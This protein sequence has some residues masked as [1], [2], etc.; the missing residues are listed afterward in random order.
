[1]SHTTRAARLFYG[2]LGLL[3]LF[4]IILVRGEAGAYFN[5]LWLPF[6]LG[7]LLSIA[8]GLLFLL[9]WQKKKLVLSRTS[10]NLWFFALLLTALVLRVF[11]SLR[12]SGVEN[13]VQCFTA[14]AGMLAED[15][16]S[17]FY[18]SGLFTDYPPGYLYPLALMGR[19]VLALELPLLSPAGVL[20]VTLPAL[21]C[22]LALAALAYC[23][24]AKISN[25]AALF[26]GALVLFCPPLMYNSAVWKQV[27][28]ALILALVATLLLLQK[29]RWLLCAL[30][31]ALAVLLKPQAF[32]FGPLLAVGF[33]LP[34]ISGA[35][36]PRR[37]LLRTLGAGALCL[38]A[39]FLL[40]MPFSGGQP[41][42][43]LLERYFNTTTFYQCASLNAGN[44]FALVGANW[45]PLESRWLLTASQWGF[46]LLIL[47]TAGLCLLAYYASRRGTLNFCLLGA[48]Y[49]CGVFTLAHTMHERYLLPALVLLLFA[50]LQLRDK[51]LL[52]L[53][54]W[55]GFVSLLNLSLAYAYLLDLEALFALAFGYSIRLLGLIELVLFLALAALT[56]DISLRPATARGKGR[57]PAALA[58]L[59]GLWESGAGNA[60]TAPKNA[61]QAGS[62][63][64]KR[65]AGAGGET[66]SDAEPV[67]RWTKQ[68][69][70][71]LLLPLL[72]CAAV[73]FLFLGSRAV[74]ERGVTLGE[75]ESVSFTLSAAPAQLWLYGGIGDGRLSLVDD[76]TDEELLS[77]ERGFND[78]YRWQIY[79]LT[80]SGTR[81]TLSG[82]HLTI[83]ELVFLCAQGETI[84]SSCLTPY[85][86]L[87]DE[88]EKR[89]ARPSY[90]NGMYFD[91]VYHA[92]TAYEYLRGLPVYETTH[93][94]LGKELIMAGIAL[95]GMNPF[96]WRIMGVL[97]GVL[98]VPLLY[99]LARRLLKDRETAF[100]C[101]CMLALDCMRYTQSRIATLDV[102]VVLFILLSYY[103]LLRFLQTD[104]LRAQWKALLWPLFLCGAAFGLGCAA[105]WTGIY[106]GIGLCFIFFFAL[107]RVWRD[108]P[109]ERPLFYRRCG[110]V[111]PTC[112]VFFVAIP[113]LLYAGSYLLIYRLS[114]E[115][116]TLSGILSQQQVMFSYHS[117]L[118]ATHTF[119]SHWWSWPLIARPVWY[120][121]GE[122]MAPGVMDTIAAMGNPAVW[123][124]ALLAVLAMLLY[125]L[126]GGRDRASLFVVL[127]LAAQ[128]LPWVPVTR[129]TFLYHYFPCVPFI[130]LALGWFLLR[131]QRAFPRLKALKTGLMLAA[132]ALFFAF[133][134]VMSGLPVTKSWVKMLQWFPS[135]YFGA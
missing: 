48:F 14:W 27:D 4:F 65:P 44:L 68:D 56:L 41:P 107:Y 57:V 3:C 26:A 89:P 81:F 22:D 93:P 16:F 23:C 9:L 50:F 100:F 102:F 97:F 12:T 30:C 2:L 118:T 63:R 117:Q 115:A 42:F 96:G 72:F 116:P 92:R 67:P 135:W 79:D 8:L 87:F 120:Y 5:E 28:S 43:W 34:L 113:L 40:A 70:L 99:L 13:D 36:R 119:S 129:A 1:M 21:L 64:G 11:L 91:E 15:G 98:L 122:G 60:D 82:D 52:Y 128:Y 35:E 25:Q 84:A 54:F 80:T 133:F 39:V 33:L 59:L 31:Y 18:T 20:L 69:T 66:L 110:V 123:W 71:Y 53:F 61:P 86:P 24:A 126:L 104:F 124:P 17:S 103:F 108:S 6:A 114:G 29:K 134:P 125:R 83:N 74:P 109:C 46:L 10:A 112:V 7:G 77:L 47:L 38:G 95:F 132:G 88:S 45:L 131:A 78:I 106:S 58:A 37:V 127:A 105:K 121:L 130:L 49:G 32:I 90:Q 75:G 111:L 76:D 101:T 73:S 62:L 19:L 85:A 51:R 55:Q 94:P